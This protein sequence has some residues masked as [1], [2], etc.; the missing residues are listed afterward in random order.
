MLKH[1]TYYAFKLNCSSLGLIISCVFV[2]YFDRITT[3]EALYCRT[4]IM[5][6]AHTCYIDISGVHGCMSPALN[7]SSVLQHF[8]CGNGSKYAMN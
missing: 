2:A 6:G 3:F 7:G 5:D 1:P 8:E 4:S